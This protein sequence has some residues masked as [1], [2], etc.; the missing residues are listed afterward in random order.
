VGCRSAPP[1]TS[2]KPVPIN[3]IVPTVADRP[4]RRSSELDVTMSKPTAPRSKGKG[5]Y[6]RSRPPTS[7]L[8]TPI[9]AID[10]APV[11]TATSPT[12]VGRISTVMRKPAS[13]TTVVEVRRR[14]S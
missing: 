1:R 11:P 10:N 3:R 4:C 8:F 7:R 13:T 9:S 2:P 12:D 5:R 14:A 6:D